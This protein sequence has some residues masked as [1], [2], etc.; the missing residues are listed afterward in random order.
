MRSLKKFIL[1]IIS[2]FYDEPDFKGFS[3]VRFCFFIA[4]VMLF[5]TWVM[6]LFYDKNIEILVAM[7]GAPALT[8]FQ[9]LGK[10]VIERNQY[11]GTSEE[12]HHTE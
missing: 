1:D 12:F 10:R 8:I 7:L 6:V 3:N 11:H 4:M 2:A 5:V 9:Y